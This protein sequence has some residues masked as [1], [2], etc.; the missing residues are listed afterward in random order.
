MDIW[1]FAPITLYD[2]ASEEK[3]PG[4]GQQD[5]RTD[6]VARNLL[7]GKVIDSSGQDDSLCGDAATASQS[8]KQHAKSLL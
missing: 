3:R 5:I 2:N 1:I 8:V 6:I 7:Y 4:T